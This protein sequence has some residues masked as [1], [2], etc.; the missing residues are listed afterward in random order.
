M[1]PTPLLRQLA[2]NSTTQTK[3]PLPQ[4]FSPGPV[5][6]LTPPK[7]DFLPSH[8]NAPTTLPPA[9]IPP[10]KIDMDGFMK[11]PIP[12]I[13]YH[14]AKSY[15]TFYKAG[16]K[17]VFANQKIRKLLKKEVMKGFNHIQI[18]G[19][20]NIVMTRSE[21]QMLI[22]TKRDVRKMPCTLPPFFGLR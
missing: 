8:I 16:I 6:R 9:L 14:R 5:P 11:F 2:A 3:L 19:S 15:Y 20:A 10:P 4:I 7:A 22:R 12:R 1:R 13:L 17:Q 21:F 18:P